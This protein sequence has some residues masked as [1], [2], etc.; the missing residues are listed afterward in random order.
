MLPSHHD[1]CNFNFFQ[2]LFLVMVLK[3][4][5]LPSS[6]SPMRGSGKERIQRN[7]TCL[8][9]VFGAMPICVVRK[10]AVQFTGQ[11]WQLD[12]LTNTSWIHEQSNSVVSG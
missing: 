3:C 4:V 9:R 2:R 12:P 10:V 8:E 7:R 5:N 6:T 1:G 11:W